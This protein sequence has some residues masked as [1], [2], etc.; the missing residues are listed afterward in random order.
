[1]KSRPERYVITHNEE[2]Y[3]LFF[4]IL[5]VQTLIFMPHFIP[6]VVMAGMTRQNNGEYS[7]QRQKI[8]PPPPPR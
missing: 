3:L 1:M 6:I 4:P 2:L 8:I 5:A 7:F